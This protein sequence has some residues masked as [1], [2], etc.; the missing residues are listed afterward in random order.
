MR[1]KQ[2]ASSNKPLNINSLSKQIEEAVDVLRNGGIIAFPTE[3]SYGLGVDP[4][5][6][7]SVEKLY[8]LKKRDS[9]KPIL[10]LIDSAKKLSTCTAS[11]PKQYHSLMS[12]YWPGPLTLI[13]PASKN[14]PE[15]LKGGKDTVAIRQSPHKVAN[16]IVE[17]FAQPITATSANISNHKPAVSAKECLTI[18]GNN[19][20]YIIDNNEKGS[21]TFSTIVGLVDNKL[22]VF[23]QG[24]LTIPEIGK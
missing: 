2:N 19:I 7:L 1:K 3:T 18:F 24:V 11:V 17:Q 22:T 9:S 12:A 10:L 5:N 6:K 4:F 13:F 21:N 15:I 20:D 14:I 16:S 23:R 8:R